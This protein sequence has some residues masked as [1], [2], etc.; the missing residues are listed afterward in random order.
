MRITNLLCIALLAMAPQLRAEQPLPPLT[1]PAT[2]E[3]HPG[4]FVWAD[5]FSNDVNATRRFYEQLF[6]WELRWISEPPDPYGIFS[7]DGYD[8]AGLA[9]RDVEGADAYARWV[10]YLSVADA[11]QAAQVVERLGGR[12]LLAQSVAERGKFAI[13]SSANDVLLGA[14]TSSSGD[15]DD[16][17]SMEGQWIWRQLYVWDLDDAVSILKSIVPLEAQRA[18]DSEYGDMLLTSGGYA[19]A[20]VTA[21]SAGSKEAP[22]WIGYVRVADA[23]AMAARA[24]QLGG[25]VLFE[26]DDGNMTIV[27]DPGGALVGLVEYTYPDT[28]DAQ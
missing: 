3:L 8:V 25:R 6:G 1:N 26:T 22:T 16:V 17:Q 18:D 21:L 27:G 10:H 5:I 19:R 13:F 11:S 24:K 2:M 28:G 4:K 20:G 7:A 9:Y 12:T 15:P 23:T 14:M